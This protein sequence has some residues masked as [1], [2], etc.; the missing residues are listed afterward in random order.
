[1]LA[2]SLWL[3][4]LLVLNPFFWLSTLYYGHFDAVVG[5]F[6]LLAV[7]SI[8]RNRE[9]SS[10]IWIALA[11]ALKMFPVVIIPALVRSWAKQ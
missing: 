8:E 9:W 7:L 6:V 3:V 2:P 10:G 11:T 4:C 1:M 5:L